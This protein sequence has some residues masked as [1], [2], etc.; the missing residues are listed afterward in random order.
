MI[1]AYVHMDETTPH[2]HFLFIPIVDEK[3][4]ER[5]ASRQGTKG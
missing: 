3:K 5:K 1:S 2:M 4:V